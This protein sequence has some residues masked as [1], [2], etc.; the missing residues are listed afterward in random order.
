MAAKL[1]CF[2]IMQ[3][4][5]ELVRENAWK[6]VCSEDFKQ[7][8]QN[9]TGLTEGNSRLVSFVHLFWLF[10]VGFVS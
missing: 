4:S 2:C 7:G 6:N 9:E 1:P 10:K 8:Y 3:L 5:T